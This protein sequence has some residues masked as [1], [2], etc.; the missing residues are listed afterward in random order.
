MDPNPDTTVLHDE[1][2]EAIDSVTVLGVVR[3]AVHAIVGAG[4][5]FDETADDNSVAQGDTLLEVLNLPY[6]NNGTVWIRAQ[7]GTDN[8]SAGTANQGQLVGGLVTDPL[9]VFADGDFSLL[10]FDVAGRLMVNMGGVALETDDD[11]IA[12]G[13][14]HET[15]IPLTYGYDGTNWRRVRVKSAAAATSDERLMHLS[16]MSVLAM[17]DTSAPAGSMEIPLA[18]NRN[19]GAVATETGYY[20]PTRASVMGYDASQAVGSQSVPVA[21]RVGTVFTSAL[22]GL[23]T[24]SRMSYQ[25]PAGVWQAVEANVIAT[26]AGVATGTPR[27]IY[28]ISSIFGFDNTAAAV[29][30]PVEARSYTN[31]DGSALSLLALGVTAN[32]FGR[33]G[34]SG[35][36][37]Q[38]FSDLASAVS[39]RVAANSRGLHTNSLTVGLDNT[40]AA[41]LRPVEARGYAAIADAIIGLVTNSRLTGRDESTGNWTSIQE[42]LYSSVSGRAVGGL[43]SLCTTAFVTG[44]DNTGAAVLRPV[45]ARNYDADADV[46]AALIGLTTNSRLAVYDAASGNFVRW[47]AD[48]PSALAGR[49]TNTVY[50]ADANSILF[51]TDNTAA[52]VLRPVEARNCDADADVTASL[53]GLLTNSRV[54]LY[55]TNS[56]GWSLARMTNGTIS[57][58]AIA[59]FSGAHAWS[60]CAGLDNT[61]AAVLRPVEAR[62][63]AGYSGAAATLLGLNTLSNLYVQDG[64]SALMVLGRGDAPGN[65]LAGRSNAIECIWTLSVTAGH[66][67]G[68]NVLF[69]VEARNFDAAAD[70]ASTLVGLLTNS[71]L[72][73]YDSAAGNFE[74]LFGVIAGSI[75]GISPA[76]QEAALA[77]AIC[78]GFDSTGAAVLR[79][80]EARN[81]D[82]S[83]DVAAALIGLTT[84]SRMAVIDGTVGDFAAITGDLASAISGR[85]PGSV[86]GMYSNSVTSGLDNTG[87]AVLRPVEARNFDAAGDVAAS[88]I[89]LLVNARTSVYDS[90]ALSEWGVQDGTSA[91]S[92]GGTASEV[93]R[94]AVI[95]QA[96]ADEFAAARRG[97]R[98]YGTHQTPGTLIT[99]QTSFVATTPTLMYRINSAAIRAI[100]RSLSISI[101]N[102]PGGLVY[103]TVAIDTADRY[104][105]A[106]TAVTLQN[107]N[108]ESATTAVGLHYFNPTA[109]AAGAGT[110]YLGTWTCPAT[111]GANV[112]LDFGD[113]VLLGHTAATF[114]VYI[115]AATTAPQLTHVLDIEEV[116]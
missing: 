111:A 23:L 91:A 22:I 112:D 84:N 54:A 39:G 46:A 20:L 44:L 17:I 79:P 13:A 10:H 45:E 103:V 38:V 72:S 97:K 56:G 16:T 74:R 49:A 71:R 31:W 85:L 78:T 21:A 96:R 33:D 70:V 6:V 53:I 11:S 62:S 87:A 12:S 110:R 107:S 36:L 83:A 1:N 61:G 19:V 60:A 64:A 59:S 57:G 93:L 69:P 108:E 32:V 47:Y 102:T 86:R 18:A 50:A 90:I 35:G 63:V 92:A 5:V 82:A 77:A 27:G 73:V 55:D 4:G 40:G 109:N 98:F 48:V 67:S 8:A 94:G 26:A 68:A 76:G 15:I 99:A 25:D 41:V 95:Y 80:V 2:Y 113:G 100:I 115:W 116:A 30:R 81:F 42:I 24:N 114:L 37:G 75:S 43:G 58:L 28:S 88:L 104:D 14:D 29:L 9:D 51:G 66:D 7:G 89:G 101:A 65:T 106:G 3:L 105:S 34:T 52:A